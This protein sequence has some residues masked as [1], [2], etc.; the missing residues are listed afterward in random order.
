MGGA[1]RVRGFCIM[2]GKSPGA[3]W[4]DGLRGL[5][6]VS[7]QLCPVP[8]GIPETDAPVAGIEHV[9][10]V[11]RRVEPTLVGGFGIVGSDV[12]VFSAPG[13]SCQAGAIGG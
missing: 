4:S 7:E 11:A 13:G 6:S 12:N 8:A 5:A 3:R 2:P 9:P 1:E 10:V